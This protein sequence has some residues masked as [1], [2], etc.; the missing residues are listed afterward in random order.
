LYGVLF[1]EFKLGRLGKGRGDAGV[2]VE[3]S[4]LIKP[5]DLK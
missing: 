3:V 5:K 2:A 1:I 4:S